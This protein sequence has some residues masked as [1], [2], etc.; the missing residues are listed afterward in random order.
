MAKSV[1]DKLELSA[2]KGWGKG[3]QDHREKVQLFMP[4]VCLASIESLERA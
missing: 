4:A 1:G 2:S 3:R